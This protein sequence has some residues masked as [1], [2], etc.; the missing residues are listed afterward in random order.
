MPSF[1]GETFVEELDGSRLR[2]QLAL[3]RGLMADGRWRTLEQI[4]TATDAPAP[5]VSARLRDLRKEKF[6]GHVVER[7]RCGE[8]SGLFE[9]RV[10]LH[11]S[12]VPSTLVLCSFAHGRQY[13]VH[14]SVARFAPN[15]ADEW[16]V[17]GALAPFGLRGEALKLRNFK[18]PL[19][20]YK[21]A[22]YAA[23]K[24]RR[25]LVERDLEALRTAAEAAED[26]TVALCCW[27]PHSQPAQE[28]LERFGTFACHLLLLRRP[29]ENRGF[30]VVLGRAHAARGVREWRVGG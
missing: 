9:Y 14:F 8:T 5:S 26:R 19:A 11:R 24:A 10:L 30:K 16:P 15:F 25:E 28:Q 21:A 22:Y 4:S 20:D 12:K 3:V 18:N 27:C 13:P 7:R 17:L 1:D 29:L 6:G 23:L 2:R